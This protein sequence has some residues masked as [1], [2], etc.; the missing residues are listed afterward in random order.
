M[1]LKPCE[2]GSE[3]TYSITVKPMQE[4]LKTPHTLEK[5]N[6]GNGCVCTLEKVIPANAE[7]MVFDSLC[8][9]ELTITVLKFYK[10]LKNLHCW[11]SPIYFL[12]AYCLYTVFHTKY[13]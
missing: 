12:F 11:K 10:Q 3:W 4:G 8:V 1:T 9:C 2:N 7:G 13:I 5:C 6:V